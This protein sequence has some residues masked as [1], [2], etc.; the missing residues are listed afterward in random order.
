MTAIRIAVVGL[1]NFGRL[2]A[3]TVAQL[4]ECELAGIA[5][6]RAATVSAA[7]EAFPGVPVWSDLDRAIA[8]CDAEAWIVASSTASH[9]PITRKLLAAGKY[10]LLE[11]P[12]AESLAVAETL[13]PLV[14][15]NSSNLM[16]GHVVLFNSEFRQLANEAQRRGKL[17]YIDC[18]RH[19]PTGTLAA[20]PGESPLHLTMVHDLYCL[21]ALTAG[22]EPSSFHATLRRNADGNCDL[23]VARLVWPDGLVAS[24]AASFLTPDGM[25]SDGYDRLE[26]FGEGWSAR[27]NS[28]PRPLEIW[29]KKAAWPLAL[30]IMTG[31]APS[32]M[33]AEEIRAFCRVVQGELP[34]PIGARYCDGLQVQRWL[35]ALEQ[36]A[37]GGAA[38]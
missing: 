21:Q 34:V 13:A 8:E 5:V 9:A 4:A 32:G 27:I 15:A 1:G 30:E 23:A 33:L 7:N 11:K 14:A 2:H 19:R 36:S 22:R 12:M 10:V 28:N 37:Q 31:T 35:E 6:R 20:F 38:C 3:Q 25:P 16:L 18:V 26:L 24:L 29:D 17:S